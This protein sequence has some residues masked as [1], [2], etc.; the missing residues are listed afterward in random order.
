MSVRGRTMARGTAACR[1][2]ETCA[3]GRRGYS[4][5]AG[6]PRRAAPGCP[7]VQW[8][9]S[10][11]ERGDWPGPAGRA[12]TGGGGRNGGKR[13]SMDVAAAGS[14]FP[15]AKGGRRP[16]PAQVPDAVA[17]ET[18]IIQPTASRQSD[19][20]AA[21]TGAAPGGTRA[22]PSRRPKPARTRLFRPTQRPARDGRGRHGQKP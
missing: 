14:R 15:G 12:C 19:R 18:G 6:E 1:R 13:F 2:G 16:R 17:A 9:C 22:G 5:P 20:T 11:R 4:A 7:Q 21:G 10:S 8:R 3:L